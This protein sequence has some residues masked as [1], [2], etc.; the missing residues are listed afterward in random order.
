[1]KKLTL[2]LTILA[3]A[4]V[5]VASAQAAPLWP[6]NSNAS[7]TTGT[8]YLC[9]KNG[10]PYWNNDVWFYNLAGNNYLRRGRM[11]SFPAFT[12][13]DVRVTLVHKSSFYGPNSFGDIFEWTDNDLQ[14]QCALEVSRPYAYNIQTLRF[15]NCTHGDTLSCI[16]IGH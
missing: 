8:T 1:V 3:L 14:E 10:S 7:G 2:V 9:Q 11:V 6:K 13:S 12:G 15:Y 5:T 4:L 16:P